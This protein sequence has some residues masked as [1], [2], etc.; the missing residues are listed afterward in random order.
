MRPRALRKPPHLCYGKRINRERS[1]IAFTAGKLKQGAAI[2]RLR[3]L[4]SVYEKP[5]ALR[6]RFGLKR[7]KLSPSQKFLRMLGG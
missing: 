2:R 3:T 6:S 4:R 1:V 5:Q 7:K